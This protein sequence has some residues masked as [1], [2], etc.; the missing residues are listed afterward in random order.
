MTPEPTAVGNHQANGGSRTCGG[1]GE[2][3]CMHFD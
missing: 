3:S 1:A 2:E